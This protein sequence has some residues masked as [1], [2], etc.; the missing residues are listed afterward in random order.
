MSERSGI[1]KLSICVP[2]RNR[3]DCFKQTILDLIDSPRADIEIVIADNSDDASV[4]NGFMA[5]LGDDRIRYLPSAA[6]PL[7]MA[8]NWERTVAATTGAWVTVIGDDDYVDPDIVDR[9]V[10]IEA[11]APQ[12][13][14]IGWNRAPFQWGSARTEAKSVPVSLANRIM[15]HTRHQLEIRLFGWAAAT[16]LPQCPYG[17]YHGAIPRRTL[18][19]I[20]RDHQGRLFE[21]PTVDYD[22][23][24]KLIS[25]STDF[26]YVNRP[27]S[28][29]GVAAASNSAAVGNSAG[30]QRAVAA[31]RSE[32]GD[33]FEAVTLAAGF[34]FRSDSGVA[35]NIMAAQVW[36]KTRYGFVHDGWQDNFARCVTLECSLWKDRAEFDSHVATIE[37]AFR[38][39]DGGRY[40]PLF[41]PR[42]AGSA[43]GPAFLGVHDA[44]LH[45]GQ[46]VAGSQTPRAF[47]R[48]L[49]DI[50]PDFD[51]MENVL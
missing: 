3:Q 33:A 28:I 22:F 21:H 31:Y 14:A 24:H 17:I 15:R 11:R 27:I 19:R 2:S 44:H 43:S 13:E 26:V 50:L 39:W 25:T 41:Q 42:F 18:E 48:V 4:M 29:L 45:I 12:V 36:F 38:S 16:Y 8:D 32:Y 34:P 23:M 37:A 46:D 51:A 20:A 7:S 5:G 10:E 30:T 40:L 47:Y 49:Q 6:A 35:G 9:I 1:P